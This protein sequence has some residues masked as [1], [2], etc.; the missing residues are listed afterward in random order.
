MG[1]F[2][3]PSFPSR[4]VSRAPHFFPPAFARPYYSRFRRGSWLHIQSMSSLPS[5]FHRSAGGTPKPLTQGFYLF[6]YLFHL[7]Q[8][9][10]VLEGLKGLSMVNGMFR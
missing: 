5:Y 7:S 10:Q 8:A 9:R 3:P 1:W 6:I 2:P 4:Y